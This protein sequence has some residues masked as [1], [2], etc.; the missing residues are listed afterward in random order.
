MENAR[1]SQTTGMGEMQDWEGGYSIM[2]CTHTSLHVHVLCPQ[3]YHRHITYT[4]TYMYIHIHKYIHTYMYIHTQIH[5]HVHTHTQIHTYIHVHTCTYTHKYIHT[6]TCTHT[7][8]Y[9]H[10]YMYIHT[11]VYINTYLQVGV[12][13]PEGN[14]NLKVYLIPTSSLT[15]DLGQSSSLPSIIL[16]SSIIR[17]YYER[18]ST[19]ASC[20]IC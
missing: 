19:Y 17:Y 5:I 16:S 12:V 9:T 1:V 15:Y 4:H 20:L 18:L 10:T 3:T 6:H 8:I 14:E 13:H 7:Q 2:G 11:H